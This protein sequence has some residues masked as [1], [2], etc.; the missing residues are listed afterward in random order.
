MTSVLQG[1]LGDWEESLE[2]MLKA[3]ELNPELGRIACAAG[4][5]CW[6]L[7]RYPEAIRYHKQAIKLTPD[8]PCPYYCEVNIYLNW[9]GSTARGADCSWKSYRKASTSRR[10]RPSTIRGS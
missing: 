5:M 6:G 3:M 9:D 1:Q 4:G 8:R 7:Q 10:S 2:T